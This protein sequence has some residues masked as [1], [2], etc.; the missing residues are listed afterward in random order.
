MIID[1]RLVFPLWVVDFLEAIRLG[2][3]R[4]ITL[5]LKC[6]K[7]I[8][9]LPVFPLLYCL[10]LGSSQPL[11]NQIY[12]LVPDIFLDFVCQHRELL[13]RSD[14]FVLSDEESLINSRG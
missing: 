1:I 9:I 12:V 5:Q 8:V 7:G 2:I 6:N 13:Q 10:A 3:A 4:N 11:L 14:P